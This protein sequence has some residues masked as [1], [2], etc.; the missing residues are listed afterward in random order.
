MATGPFGQRQEGCEGD[1]AHGATRPQQ[2]RQGA[3]KAPEQRDGRGQCHNGEGHDRQH[4]AAI[5]EKGRTEPMKGDGEIAEAVGETDSESGAEEF[6]PAG[7]AFGA[8]EAPD[9]D[10]H[11]QKQCRQDVE[12]WNAQGA[13]GAGYHEQQKAP[14]A[15]RQHGVLS[16]PGH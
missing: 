16:D 11:G 15:M 13:D 5:D 3:G 1:D 14:P 4:D 12:R 10:R 6:A 7:Q 9:P 8:I 2:V